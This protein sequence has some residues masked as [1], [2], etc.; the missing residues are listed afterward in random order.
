MKHFTSV[1]WSLSKLLQISSATNHLPICTE[2]TD[3]KNRLPKTTIY[4]VKRTV[5]KMGER[6]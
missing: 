6:M 5:P 4:V 2:D 1:L 3:S